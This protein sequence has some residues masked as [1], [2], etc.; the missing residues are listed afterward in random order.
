MP[1][2]L[3]DP[4]ELADVLARIDTAT[5]DRTDVKRAVQHYLARLRQ[6]APGASVEVRVPPFA[7][8]QVVAGGRHTRGTPPAVV[9]VSAEGFLALARGRA[10]WEEV[11]L[12]A[13]G[14]G[15]D[16]SGYF[17]LVEPEAPTP[18]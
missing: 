15:S 13:S 16:L 9:E 3:L 7:A 5:A 17:P 2:R 8:V 10:R 6:V 1:I 11:A 12:T 18:T 4:S 14:Q